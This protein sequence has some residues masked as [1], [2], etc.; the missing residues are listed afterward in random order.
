M[1]YGQQVRPREIAQFL[2]LDKRMPRSLAFCVEKMVDNLGYLSANYGT[3]SGALDLTEALEDNRLNQSID[4]I[5]EAG[6]HEFIQDVLR[7]IAAIGA[8]AETDF[9]FYE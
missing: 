2:I 7:D 4:A 6:L 1:T 8:Q 9:R 5:F 3:R